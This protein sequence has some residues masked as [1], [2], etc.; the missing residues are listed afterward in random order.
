MG[1]GALFDDHLIQ[2]KVVTG[3]LNAQKASERNPGICC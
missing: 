2:F 1:R 3:T